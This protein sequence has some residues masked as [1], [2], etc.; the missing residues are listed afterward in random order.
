M[1]IPVLLIAWELIY[2]D[3]PTAARLIL[4]AM[5]G[6]LTIP[7]LIGK[8]Q[9]SSPLAQLDRYHAVITLQQFLETCSAY[10]GQ[11]TYSTPSPVITGAF[12]CITLTIAAALRSRT[13][14]FAWIF[15]MVSA[16]PVAFIPARNAFAFYIPLAAWTL[17]L[18]ALIVE[19]RDRLLRRP[20]TTIAATAT[21][22]I[23][24]LLLLRAHRI[25]RHRMGGTDLLGQPLIRR[26][27]TNLSARHPVFPKGARVVAVNDPFTPDPYELVLLL[28]LYAND[29]TIT[30]DH[31]SQPNA[32]QRHPDLEW[33]GSLL[34]SGGTHRRIQRIVQQPYL[35][36]IRAD[37]CAVL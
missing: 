36:M 37:L 21:F 23:A 28:R 11:L 27:T 32:A 15:A 6:A 17:Y 22:L 34:M 20:R 12:F 2:P 24:L 14:L 29:P 18:A 19:L 31:A 8:L 1:A 13:L 7:Y 33:S 35:V 5:L 26:V 4:P 9:P 16:L 25:Q 30:V 10:L 3:R